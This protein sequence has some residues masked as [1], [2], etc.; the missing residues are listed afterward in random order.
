[1]LLRASGQETG[2]TYDLS[3]I[4]G[5]GSDDG[6]VGAGQQ[7]LAFAD[8]LLGSDSAAL[9]RAR[10]SLR[11]AVGDEGLVDAAAVAATFNAIDRIADATGIPLEEAKAA[12]TADFREALAIDSYAE[13]RV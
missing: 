4:N 7:L 8:T 10:G 2:K 1:M 5:D 12:A 9:D 13:G 6:G 3:A 11:Q